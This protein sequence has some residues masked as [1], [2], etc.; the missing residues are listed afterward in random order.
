MHTSL[1]SEDKSSCTIL[2]HLQPVQ[3]TTRDIKKQRITVVNTRYQERI[4]EC[5]ASILGDKLSNVTDNAQL[6]VP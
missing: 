2:K 1:D 4:D 3:E 5:S 6:Q